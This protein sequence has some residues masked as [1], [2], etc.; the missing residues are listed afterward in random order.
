MKALAWFL[1]FA[2]LWAQAA[3]DPVAA[4]ARSVTAE[5]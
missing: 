5:G 1:A 2:P 3:G 4:A